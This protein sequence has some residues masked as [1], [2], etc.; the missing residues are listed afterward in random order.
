[1]FQDENRALLDQEQ[2]MLTTKLT[3]VKDRFIG[4]L[5]EIFNKLAEELKN[6]ILTSESVRDYLVTQSEDKIHQVLEQFAFSPQ[7]IENY[8][9]RL[10][11]KQQDDSNNLMYIQ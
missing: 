5:Q 9:K 7:R 4:Y 6:Q 11:I 8:V 1:M 3:A 2:Q 10:Q